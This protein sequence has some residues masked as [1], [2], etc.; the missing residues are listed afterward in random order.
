VRAV[1]ADSGLDWTVLINIGA[2]DRTGLQ[3]FTNTVPGA[4]NSA[5]NS[6]LPF[7]LPR[8]SMR[9]GL[10]LQEVHEELDQL[11]GRLIEW[12]GPEAS[13]PALVRRLAEVQGQ[14][15][16]MTT[17][18]DQYWAYRASL[19]DQV[20]EKPRS[21][22]QQTSASD[23]E[24]RMHPEDRRRLQYFTA[25]GKAVKTGSAAD[26]GRLL[27]FAEPYDPLISFFVH[28]E[29]AEI[30]SRSAERDYARELRLRLHAVFFS[31]PRDAS[32]RNVVA[33]LKLLREHPESEPDPEARWDD[34]NA[35]LQALKMKWEARIGVRPANIREAV[36]D[37]D[38]TV[39]A[40]EQTFQTLDALT[41]EAG[42][43]AELWTARR[44]ALEKTLI[45]PVRTYQ[46]ELVPLLHRRPAADEHAPVDPGPDAGDKPDAEEKADAE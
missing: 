21:Q 39:L 5:C 18:S 45:R 35:L 44:S 33:A 34:L 40:A 31:S 36:N 38:T 27:K 17:Y 7:S 26:I 2:L 9:W 42:L 29:A 25:L 16:L 20:K 12:L 32:L 41:A 1:L 11:A 30:S 19:R 4:I 22:I 6:R 8:D 23:D 15:E 3:K 14:Q 46:L 43:P 37:I 10:K 28:E 24:P 13:T